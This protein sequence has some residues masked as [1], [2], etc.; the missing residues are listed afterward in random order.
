M[1]PKVVGAALLLAGLTLLSSCG[2]SGGTAGPAADLTGTVREV[3]KSTPVAG[4]TVTAG[5]LEA[6]TAADGTYEI[7]GAPVGD[8]TLAVT[9]DGYEPS[10]QAVTV[11]E[12]ANQRDVQ[13]TV[14]TWYDLGRYGAYIPPHVERLRGVLLFIG[15]FEAFSSTLGL[16]GGTPNPIFPNWHLALRQFVTSHDLVL[17]GE[18]VDRAV[19]T[20]GSTLFLSALNALASGAPH[21]PELQQAPALLL[22][23]SWG[24]CRAYEAAAAHGARVIGFITMKGGCHPETGQ[25]GARAV[26]GY[27]FIGGN[28]DPFRQKNITAAFEANRPA[29][30]LWALAVEPGTGHAAPADLGLLTRWMSRVLQLR[31][32]ANPPPGQSVPLQLVDEADGWLGNLGTFEICA[33][34]CYPGSSDAAAWLPD[35]GTA[36]DWQEM[37]S[38]GG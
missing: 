21:H 37:V 18:D 25:P 16:V 26:P 11:Q 12:G 35:E 10:T 28:D 32:P 1:T 13:L 4:A 36:T 15:G 3:T 19:I 14:K 23:A 31:V 8:L 33:F 6:T 20:N 9:A 30:A 34:A 38:G 5:G 2:G 22:G 17:L 29:G 27:L 24:G 7:L